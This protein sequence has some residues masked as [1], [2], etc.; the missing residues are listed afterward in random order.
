MCRVKIPEGNI[1]N[2][3]IPTLEEAIR[4]ASWKKPS[5]CLDKKDVPMERTAQWMTD[6]QAEPYVMNTVHDGASA[7][8]LN[9]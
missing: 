5:E 9:E 8:F 1:T 7:R 3:R 4:W 6:M 2:D